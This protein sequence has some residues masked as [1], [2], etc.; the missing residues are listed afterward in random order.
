MVRA[1]WEDDE[2]WTEIYSEQEWKKMI[3]RACEIPAPED[4]G[5]LLCHLMVA[6]PKKALLVD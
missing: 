2:S 4:N 3:E 1:I 6:I 5:D